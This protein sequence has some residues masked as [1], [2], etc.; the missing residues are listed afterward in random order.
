MSNS[1]LVFDLEI[2]KMVK[3]VQNNNINDF[4]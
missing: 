1:G 2:V 4:D 3:I